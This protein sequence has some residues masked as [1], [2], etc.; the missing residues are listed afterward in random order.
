VT[1]E[2]ISDRCLIHLTLTVSN[3]KSLLLKCGQDGCA[4]M[5]MSG[6]WAG[7]TATLFLFDRTDIPERRHT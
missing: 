3:Y 6:D 2:C 7:H 1:F 4:S 5:S